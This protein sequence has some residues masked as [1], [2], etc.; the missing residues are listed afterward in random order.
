L[1]LITGVIFAVTMLV[2]LVYNNTMDFWEG[3]V[4]QGIFEFNKD[5]KT[6]VANHEIL[7]GNLKRSTIDVKNKENQLLQKVVIQQLASGEIEVVVDGTTRARVRDILSLPIASMF[8]SEGRLIEEK[9]LLFDVP[10]K[11]I[12]AK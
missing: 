5:G 12:A 4:S 9:V 10:M 1:Y 3:R 2:D 8:N 11:T 7:P 6:F